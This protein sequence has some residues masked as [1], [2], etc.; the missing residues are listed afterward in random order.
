M[1]INLCIEPGRKVAIIGPSGSGK[2]TM[3]I[4]IPRL[5]DVTKG[6]V[7][8]DDT[9]VRTIG[10]KTLRKTVGIVQ[11]EPFLFSTSVRENICYG[12]TRASREELY[13]AAKAANAHQFIINLPRGRQ[14]CRAGNA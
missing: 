9:D 1:A 8:I 7:L 3:A 4:L 14:N 5:Y 10:L 6:Q 13:E 2:S 12:K 11:Q